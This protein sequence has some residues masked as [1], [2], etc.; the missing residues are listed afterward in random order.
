MSNPVKNVA[1]VGAGGQVGKF[2]T[3]A[4]LK[5]GKH[6]V[7]AITRADSTSKLPEGVQVAKVNYDDQSS[8]VKALSGHQALVITMGVMA[9]AEQQTKLIEAA[10]EANVPY[11]IPNEWGTAGT[12][13]QLGKDTFLGPKAAG[14]RAHIE[15][16]GKSA[17]IGIC[18]GF[19][20]EY[21]LAG[22]PERYGFDLKKREVIFFDDGTTRLNTS[23][24]LQCGR[25]VAGLLTLDEKS[26]SQFK[27]N[28]VYISSFA[29]NQR[30]MFAALQKATGT[31]EGDWKVTSQ[32]SGERYKSGIEMLQGGNRLGFARLLYTRVFF[33]SAE[34]NYEVT[35]GLNN[36]L[37]GLPK[38]DLDEATT[39]AVGMVDELGFH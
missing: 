9:P 7:T 31:K 15:Q 18:C 23:T 5:T 30:E 22:G 27:N 1:I 24:W 32:P 20:Y 25:A 13:E 11:V 2:V 39:R 4:L 3:E 14:Y 12:N 33:P 16:L 29:L 35:Q 21:S 37:L 19:W 36:D 38:E 28:F 17:W 10:A 26:L 34:G 6:T 8:L